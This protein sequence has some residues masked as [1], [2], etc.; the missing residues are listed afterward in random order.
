MFAKAGGRRQ[1]RK[2]KKMV[3]CSWTIVYIVCVHGNNQI[4]LVKDTLKEEK[5]ERK[6]QERKEKTVKMVGLCGERYYM[7][8]HKRVCSS[9]DT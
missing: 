8:K 7:E 4:S 9:I 3:V 1:E 2:E 6:E 5:K